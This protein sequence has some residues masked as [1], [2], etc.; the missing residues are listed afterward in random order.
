MDLH[1]F[2]SFL[3][4]KQNTTNLLLQ[5]FDNNTVVPFWSTP[6]EL[7]KFTPTNPTQLKPAVTKIDTLLQNNDESSTTET[8]E[9]FQDWADTFSVV[10]EN[11]DNTLK[12]H[13]I[14]AETEGPNPTKDLQKVQEAVS[15]KTSMLPNGELFQ[16]GQRMDFCVASVK[17]H[18]TNVSLSLS[19]IRL[20]QP[21]DCV[22]K[23]KTTTTTTKRKSTQVL[24]K[25]NAKKAKTSKSKQQ[26]VV[27]ILPNPVVQQKEPNTN[28]QFS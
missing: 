21:I 25:T 12:Q 11:V 22:R 14:I 23:T 6:P 9:S 10:D 26:N 17:P 3:I 19:G 18:N 24:E 15:M 5:L 2:S 13:K 16:T 28:Q 4:W 7:A 8:E 1:Q 27:S 20:A